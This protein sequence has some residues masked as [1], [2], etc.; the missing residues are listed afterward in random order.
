MAGSLMTLDDITTRTCRSL[1]WERLLT[2]LAHEADTDSGKQACLAVQPLEARAVIEQLLEETSEALSIIQARSTL[3]VAGLPPLIDVLGRLATGA[4]LDGRELLA[5]KTTLAIARQIKASLALLAKE[6]FPRLTTFAP[7]FHAVEN[8][9]RSIENALDDGGEVKDEASSTLRSLRKEVHRIDNKIKEELLRIIHSTTLSKA[10]QEL[11]YTQRN[12]RYVLPVNASM[13]SQ[14][15]GIVH[16]SSATGLTVYVEPMAVVELANKMRIKEA[17]IE[18]EIARILQELTTLAASHHAEI[19]SSFL[20]A[21]EIDLISARAKL[22][23]RYGGHM[24]ELSRDRHFSYKQARH[25]LLILQSSIADVVANDI[26]LGGTAEHGS[27]LI[28]TGPNT[29]GKTVLLKTAG[30]FALMLRAGMLPAASPGSVAALFPIVCADIGDEQSIEQSLSTFSSHMKN[31]VEIVNNACDGMLVLL[32]EVGAG[33]DPR[34]GAALARSILEALTASGAVTIST[35]HYGEL[36]TLAYSE[37]GFI[38]GSLDFDENTLSPTYRLRLGVPGKSQ[39]T[40]IAKRLGLNDQI[41]ARARDLMQSNE[42][43]LQKVVERLE[44]KLKELDRRE[45]EALEELSQARALK[46]QADRQMNQL[47]VDAEKQRAALTKDMEEEFKLSREY[48]RHLIADLQKQPSMSKAQKAQ[49]DIEKL[50]KELG[51]TEHPVHGSQAVQPPSIRVG[52]TVR[53]RSLGQIGI[54]ET[55]PPATDDR[56]GPVSVRAGNLKIKVPMSDLEPVQGAAKAARTEKERSLSRSQ[57]SRSQT[58]GP[59]PFVRT[60]AN[61]VDLRGRRVDDAI[62]EL[63]RFLDDSVMAGVSMAMIIH[64]HGTGAVRNAVRE[65]L[66]Q[67]NYANAFRPGESFEGGDGVTLV[68]LR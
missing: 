67:S 47:S 53:V 50:K 25:P 42:E 45:R 38:N 23:L 55:V 60:A 7:R 54:V 63:E 2:F 32:D 49:A 33:T 21:V 48:I 62:L 9:F 4:S 39:A 34:E 36:K 43:D 1:Q 46:E 29:G 35:T 27:T 41:V 20:A 51:W 11:I 15:N 28:I 40:T 61:T 30:I 56:N 59:N 37:V 64:G 26:T 16:D 5:I 19:E 3:S 24:P 52:Q 65:Y 31:I 12:G 18:H 17:E 58:S 44:Q 22:A 68:D 57:V 10:L 13:R 6:F 8:V 66:S 14:I